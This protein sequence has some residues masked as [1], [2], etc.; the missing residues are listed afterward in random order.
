MVFSTKLRQ[1]FLRDREIREKLHTQLGA[2][3]KAL[4]CAPLL[5]GGVEDHAHLLCR[6]SRTITQ[7]EWV[8]ELK[9]VS[10]NWV[11]QQGEPY[12]GFEWQSG[13]AVFSVSKSNVAEVQRYIASQEQHHSRMNFQEELRALLR[14]HGLEFDEQYLW[15]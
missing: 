10:N 11:K 1:P 3:G 6:L 5:I 14:R 4:G 15:D 13:Y 12:K 7:S 9:R 2:T 8:K